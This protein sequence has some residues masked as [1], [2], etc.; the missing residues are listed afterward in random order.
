MMGHHVANK[1][2]NLRDKAV[3]T[4]EI[5]AQAPKIF[6]PDYLGSYITDPRF[7]FFHSIL[8]LAQYHLAKFY[9]ILFQESLGNYNQSFEHE[10][11]YNS[12]SVIT[13]TLSSKTLIEVYQLHLTLEFH[14]YWANR[15]R[16]NRG[17]SFFLNRK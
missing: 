15:S 1:Q 6:E 16:E 14:R 9:G 12:I 5:I 13:S 7:L 10:I 3:N 4:K 17:Q 11:P 8:P 2:V